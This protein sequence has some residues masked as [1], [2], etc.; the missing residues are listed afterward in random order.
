MATIAPRVRSAAVGLRAHAR[1]SAG[2]SR[3]QTSSRFTVGPKIRSAVGRRFGAET[4][5]CARQ[6]V[7][8]RRLRHIRSKARGLGSS[9]GKLYVSAIGWRD[10]RLGNVQIRIAIR[11]AIR[12]ELRIALGAKL[13]IAPGAELGIS[14]GAELRIRI[15]S[16]LCVGISLTL[17]IG[18]GA[19]SRRG[20]R[21]K[22]I[23]DARSFGINL[24]FRTRRRIDSRRG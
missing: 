1:L 15:G 22:I 4:S 11:A 14:L 13:C 7:G 16:N 19:Y 8:V 23:I 21:R 10:G 18:I 2:D 6:R 12:T 24:R 20:V 3:V 5:I 17:S 9:L